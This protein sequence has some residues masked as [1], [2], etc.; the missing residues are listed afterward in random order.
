MKNSLTIIQY[1][2]LLI[3]ITIS[4]SACQPNNVG[5]GA[6]GGNNNNLAQ[7]KNNRWGK[8]VNRNV[9]SIPIMFQWKFDDVSITEGGGYTLYD[10]AWHLVTITAERM[11]SPL[12]SPITVNGLD[13]A[14]VDNGDNRG[15]KVE[16]VD[17]NCKTA[18]L[19]KNGD[20]CSAYVRI[21]YDI[22]TGVDNPPLIKA[23]LVTGAYPEVAAQ[24]IIYIKPYFQLPMADL[25]PVLPIESRYYK[26]ANLANNPQEYRILSL[27]NIS[28]EPFSIATLTS[29]TNPA[30]SL[31]ER[32]GTLDNDP[33]YGPY[34]QCSLSQNDKKGQV[35]QLAS[36]ESECILVYRAN[37]IGT[38]TQE[39]DSITLTPDKRSTPPWT[40]TTYQ[41]IANYS[42]A[43][44]IPD[45]I[46]NGADMQIVKGSAHK[47]GTSMVM[48]TDGE[49]SSGKV[50]PSI[51]NFNYENIFY[52]FTPKFLNYNAPYFAEYGI[53]WLAYNTLNVD[54]NP[55][56][57]PGMK[58]L[59]DAS[60]T[61]P[62]TVG[63]VSEVLTT[64]SNALNRVE[65]GACGGAF[66]SSAATITS[67]I[68]LTK[69][70]LMHLHMENGSNGLCGGWA[71][72]ILDLDV[73]FSGMQQQ[74][75]YRVNHHGCGGGNWDIGGWISIVGNG[76]RGNDCSYTVYVTAHHGG[77]GGQCQDTQTRGYNLNFKRPYVYTQLS[78][79]ANFTPSRDA[80]TYIGVYKQ[81][82]YA[83]L[84]TQGGVVGISVYC[85]RGGL[86]CKANGVYRNGLSSTN[87]LYNIGLG[88]GD[89]LYDTNVKFT[90]SDGYDL[91]GFEVKKEGG[92]N[93][94]L[95]S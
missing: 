36:M 6:T 75:I 56:F 77:V 92:R 26:G 86:Y 52:T 70:G 63:K 81:N 32:Q 57:Y 76:C 89:V 19:Q 28:L 65:V 51:Y 67:K 22:T 71:G 72:Q 41:L 74:E 33:Y 69:K 46:I 11:D 21:S 35:N 39:V 82:L 66:A 73:P 48:E 1:L 85:E 9:K 54:N 37:P 16:I 45:L 95:S 78:Q 83:S 58:I 59:T 31:M 62:V 30:F 44:P 25:R 50:T 2:S 4:L 93:A 34:K 14:L 94:K 64:N 43:K 5:G 7:S 91:S 18:L 29:A 42:N 38:R 68:E 84:G 24:K 88:T 87:L 8:N 10:I 23:Q 47:S 17:I 40:A 3:F 79:L 20:S 60:S 80:M 55:A 90:R 53:P 12:E 13:F 27:K 15:E 49:L 61:N